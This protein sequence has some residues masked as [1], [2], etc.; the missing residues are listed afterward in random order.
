MVRLHDPRVRV[1]QERHLDTGEVQELYANV[2]K[3]GYN[4]AEFLVDFGRAFADTDA[5]FHLRMITTPADMK[6]LLALLTRSVHDYEQE[7][8]VLPEDPDR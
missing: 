5:R 6:R 3:V 8:G 2:F 4:A 7:F 1:H